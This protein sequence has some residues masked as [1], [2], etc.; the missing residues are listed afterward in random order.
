MGSRSLERD[1]DVKDL[2]WVGRGPNLRRVPRCWADGL[3]RARHG[4]VRQKQWLDG[5]AAGEELACRLAVAARPLV[6]TVVSAP[7]LLHRR[8][9]ETRHQGQSHSEDGGESQ[10]AQSIR[11]ERCSAKVGD[12]HGCASRKWRCVVSV[13]G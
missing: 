7:A 6:L 9:R 11:S 10:H 13:V 3:R 12:E 8:Q 1:R 2:A 4:Y 5:W